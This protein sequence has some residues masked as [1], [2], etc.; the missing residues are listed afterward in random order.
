ME[1]KSIESR[2]SNKKSL[3]V[4]R[5][6]AKRVWIRMTIQLIS[7]RV[8]KKVLKSESNNVLVAYKM[9]NDK[10]KNKDREKRVI[11]E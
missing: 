10:E 11:V 6:T 3:K 8:L 5:I 4:L 1:L 2:Y 9:N 7:N